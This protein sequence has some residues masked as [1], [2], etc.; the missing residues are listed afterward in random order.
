LTQPIAQYG[1]DVGI[2]VIGGYLYRGL[3]VPQLRGKYVFGDF[4]TSFGSPDG[5]LFYMTPIPGFAASQ[6]Y[7]LK[8]GVHNRPFGMYLKGMGRDEQGELYFTASSAPGPSGNTGVV[9]RMGALPCATIDFNGDGDPGTEL[10]IEAF[11]ECLAGN[12]CQTCWHLGAD[13]NGDGDVGNDADIEAFFRV[14]AG[15]TC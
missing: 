7:R 9:Y 4:S 12:C 1:R 10:D 5:H 11:F 14:L 15:G 8:I 13:F 2:A 3:L 6:I